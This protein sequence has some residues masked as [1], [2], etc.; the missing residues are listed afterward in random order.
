MARRRLHKKAYFM[1]LV[2]LHRIIKQEIFRNCKC[3]FENSYSTGFFYYH[4]S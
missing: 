4:S 3:E 1:P 2:I